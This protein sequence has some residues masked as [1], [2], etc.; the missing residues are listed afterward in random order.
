MIAEMTTTLQHSGQDL[1]RV[2]CFGKNK[3]YKIQVARTIQQRQQAWA[4]VHDAY[5]RKQYASPQADGLWYGLHDALPSTTTFL[6]TREGEAVAALTI[7]LDSPLQLPADELYKDELDTMRRQGRR[8]CEII[9][10]VNEEPDRRLCME[11]LVHM[12]RLAY[13]A[14][15]KE[16][17]AT[18]FIIT[19]N[20]RHAAYYEG[21]LLFE[22]RGE[23]RSY[24]K[25]A[26]APAVLLTLN[27]ETVRIRYAR[28]NTEC[29]GSAIRTFILDHDAEAALG[30]ML[31]Q[32]M[33]PLSHHSLRVF[34][35]K[36]RP[37]LA[38]ATAW[39][40]KHIRLQYDMESGLAPLGEQTKAA[41]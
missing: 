4:L 40:R 8:L 16:L 37:L 36:K 5:V 34:F 33:T 2:D 9:S 11:S 32:S 29:H 30:P 35:E 12:F 7:V 23:E 19:V 22:Q 18:D 14:A 24:K 21:R 31:K 41:I 10:L 20:P 13:L 3:E 28:A 1:E 17:G 15:R 26:G 6:V 38:C 25:V 27:L 39:E